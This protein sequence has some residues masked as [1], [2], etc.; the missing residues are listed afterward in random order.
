MQ[1]MKKLFCLSLVSTTALLAGVSANATGRLYVGG[2]VGMVKGDHSGNVTAHDTA[3]PYNTIDQG[4]SLSKNTPSFGFFGGYEY[5]V[6]FGFI[7]AEGFYN[8][9]K[10]DPRREYSLESTPFTVTSSVRLK[11]ENTFGFTTKIGWN[12]KRLPV[13]AYLAMSVLVSDFTFS[14]ENSDELQI[15]D[16]EGRQKR[17]LWAFAPGCGVAYDLNEKLTV[18][19]DYQYRFY[20]D[21]KLRDVNDLSTDAGMSGTLHPRD[22]SIMLGIAYKF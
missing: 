6:E 22:Q 16:A 7:A 9:E 18:R 20:Q 10:N 8:H 17:Y 4:I 11:K 13:K 1:K 5:P 15:D 19:L 2:Q 21:F 14:Y 3:D 12:V